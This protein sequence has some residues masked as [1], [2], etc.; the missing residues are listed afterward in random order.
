MNRRRRVYI[1]DAPRGFSFKDLPT[2]IPL[3]AR[4]LY[5]IGRKSCFERVCHSFIDVDDGY[6]HAFACDSFA[7]SFLQ[8]YV[9][10]CF[11]GGQ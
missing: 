6:V 9:M 4:A 2:F 8:L 10:A 1:F 5:I 3:Q 7:F 11:S